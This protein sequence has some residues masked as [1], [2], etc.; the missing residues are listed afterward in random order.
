M[1]PSEER[2]VID[3]K[4]KVVYVGPRGGRYVKK[5]GVFVSLRKMKGGNGDPTH[6]EILFNVPEPSDKNTYSTQ[7]EKRRVVDINDVTYT[8]TKYIEFTIL[9]D[10]RTGK[11]IKVTGINDLSYTNSLP[12][13]LNMTDELDFIFQNLK[14][15]TLLDIYNWFCETYKFKYKN[16]K[17]ILFNPRYTTVTHLSITIQPKYIKKSPVILI[18]N[19]NSD[20][21]S[22]DSPGK[23]YLV[24]NI[25][26]IRPPTSESHL[27]SVA[28]RTPR[29]ASRP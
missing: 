7:I 15:H 16:R 26:T 19:P 9:V 23:E 11:I 5:D 28:H 18:E 17:F 20:Y 21:K 24:T 25:G 1:K 13:D 29:Q 4:K 14:Y 12:S 2:I 8:F 27:P 10:R 22:S 3:G 6:Y